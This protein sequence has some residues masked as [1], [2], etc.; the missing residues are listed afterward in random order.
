M[1]KLNLK[2]INKNRIN[3]LRKKLNS[4][5]YLKTAINKIAAELTFLLFKDNE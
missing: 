4:P 2:V 5:E 3:E 1:N